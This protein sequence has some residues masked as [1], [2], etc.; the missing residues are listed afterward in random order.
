MYIVEQRGVHSC[1][2]DDSK[3]PSIF[4]P[5]AKTQEEREHVVTRPWSSADHE[6]SASRQPGRA[7]KVE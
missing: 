6:V 4:F 3:V 7:K 5:N 2:V 1:R